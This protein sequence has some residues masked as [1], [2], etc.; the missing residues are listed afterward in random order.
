VAAVCAASG[1]AWGGTWLW[2]GLGSN[3]NWS[4]SANWSPA[5]PPSSDDSTLLVFDN[6]S[7][8][9]PEQDLADSFRFGALVFSNHAGAFC[10]GGSTN[11]FGQPA[12]RNLQFSGTNS[13]LVVAG[14]GD[15][16]LRGALVTP[17]SG[18]TQTVTVA[19][20]MTL[21]VPWIKGG[22][23]RVMVKRGAG[24]LRVYEHEDGQHYLEKST[25]VA[26]E[27]RVE[28]GLVEMGTRTDRFVLGS[29][30][31]SWKADPAEVK[32]SYSLTVGDGAGGATS[33]V[34]RLIGPAQAQLLD[35]NLAIVV[36]ADGL[37]ALNGVQNWDADSTTCLV[38]RSGCVDVGDGALF[39]RNGHVL[40]LHGAARM[41]GRGGSALRF[42]D[43]CTNRIT[44]TGA[45]IAADAALVSTTNNAGVVF[46]V[47][48]SLACMGHLGAGGAGSH[49][50]KRGSGALALADV[51]HA[52]R[53]N[54]VEEGTL[55][56]NGVARCTG[57]VS[58]GA[59]WQVSGGAMLAGCGIISNAT[60]AV[61][62]T[63]APEGAFT[64]EKDLALL[65]GAD[66]CLDLTQAVPGQLILQKGKLTGVDNATL[67]VVA[68]GRRDLDGR[69]FRIVA[70]GGDLTGTAF[71]SVAFSGP[72]NRYAKVTTGN[73]FIDLTIRNRLAGT[74]VIME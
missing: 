11:A 1:V 65:P 18:A 47:T 57:L 45:V 51:S 42:Y 34:F 22:F 26:P 41:E 38:V 60:V 62:G 15:V 9:T 13:C 2:T 17:A 54:R 30:G 53:T 55:R 14:G 44:G 63:L 74:V 29:D 25:T 31:A 56:L 27:Y 68:D 36:Q 3:D 67:R 21:H 72:P 33:A 10:L 73:G 69:T 59:A 40:D 20:G 71:L 50:V 66:V 32:A 35:N 7:R 23:R 28:D 61:H 43:G 37:L 4:T 58:A 12:W 16:A 6:A 24:T 64:I 70:G 48:G 46:Q 52:A 49:L 8:L 5:G 39:V 19:T